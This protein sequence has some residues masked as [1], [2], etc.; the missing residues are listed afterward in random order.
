[1][2]SGSAMPAINGLLETA[3]Y[4]DDLERSVRFYQQIFGFRTFEEGSSESPAKE[5]DPRFCPLQIPGRQVLLLFRKGEFTTTSVLPGG[6][7][8]PHDGRGTLHLAFAVNADDLERWREWLSSHGVQVEGETTWPRGGV[9]LYFRDP[10]GH[11]LELATPG[12]WPIY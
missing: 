2:T 9:S 5:P 11:L 4:V 7:I 1:M 12:L 3:L 10:D 6:T 8:P